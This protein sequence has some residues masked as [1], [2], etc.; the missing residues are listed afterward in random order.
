MHW[1]DFWILSRPPIALR[2][3]VTAAAA[4]FIEGGS[5]HSLL[6]AGL[7]G[8]IF[9]AGVYAF[10]DIED[11]PEDRINHPERP[12]PAGRITVKAVRAYGVICLIAAVALA[13]FLHDRTGAMALAAMATFAAIPPLHRLTERHW[14]GRGL[15][16]FAFVF[17]AFVLGSAGAPGDLSS[18]LF[19]LA[20]AVGVLHVATRIISDEQDLEGDRARLR[21][22][23]S[24]SLAK[25]RRFIRNVLALSAALLPLPYFFGFPPL[26]LLFSL[27]PA[28]RILQQAIAWRMDQAGGRPGHALAAIVLLGACLS[29]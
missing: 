22:L 13:S 5:A 15:S 24:L 3:G 14:I 21:T 9:T 2:Y 27:P 12:L 4:G 7:S 18:R 25:A 20:E 29:R 11:L 28:L 26:Y 1:I 23:P 16:V 17:S 8:M 19:L 10:D 6:L